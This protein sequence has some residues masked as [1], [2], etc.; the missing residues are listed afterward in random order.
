MIRGKLILLQFFLKLHTSVYRKILLRMSI[1]KESSHSCPEVIGRI[2]QRYPENFRQIPGLEEIGEIL[3]RV[4]VQ[5][6]FEEYDDR[7]I[8]IAASILRVCLDFD[9]YEEQGHD[10]Q[11]ILSSL[12]SRPNDYDPK[13]IKVLE[14]VV[15]SSEKS[16]KL[17]ELPAKQLET[18]MRLVDELRMKDGFLLASAGSYIDEQLYKV[19]RNYL[20]CYDGN[21]FPS[22]IKV[23]VPR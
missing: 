11:L 13:V 7:N 5:P 1:T 15:S 8:R 21:P 17:E 20:S 2:P 14:L 16:T 18:G 19:I 9:F 3:Q 12:K 6:R 23:R 10:K 4:D 22:T